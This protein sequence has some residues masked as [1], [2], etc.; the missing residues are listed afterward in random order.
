MEKMERFGSNP[1]VVQCIAQLMM[2]SLIK[3][4]TDTYGHKLTDAVSILLE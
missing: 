4:I 1:N 2:I 3:D